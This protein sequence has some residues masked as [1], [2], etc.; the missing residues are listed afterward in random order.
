L[1]ELSKYADNLRLAADDWGEDWKTLISILMSART[2]DSVT[3]KVSTNLF[4]KYD[5][6]GLANA[7]LKDVEKIIR[8]VNFYH[9]KAKYVL[10][11]AKGIV[12]LGKVP[13]DVESLVKLSGVGRKTA[14]VFI[15]SIGGDAIGV[16][17]HVG[18]IARKLGWTTHIDPF[19]VEIDLCNL[20]P[21]SSWRK[22]NNILVKFGQSN[23]GKKEDLILEKIK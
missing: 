20:F 12:S 19:K 15:A 2:R 11:C 14:N 5:L 16:D 23:R 10:E 9:N 3:I 13:S 22:V 1:K 8:S 4:D 21:K 18:R 7:K 17:T 6:E